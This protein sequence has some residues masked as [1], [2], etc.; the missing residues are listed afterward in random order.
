MKINYIYILII[1]I[2]SNI[3]TLAQDEI[4]PLW[5]GKIPGEIYNSEYFEKEIVNNGELQRTIQV[6]NPTLLIFKP[7]RANG[8][9]ILIFPGGGYEH[10]SMNKEGKKV[11]KWLNSLGITAVILKYRLPN[12]LIMKDKSIG[13][14]Q[15]AQEAMKM[16]RQNASEW[17]INPNKIGVM[18]FSAG[19]HIA[20]TLAT[21]Y[22]LKTYSTNDTI[23]AR[24]DFSILIYPVIS[25]KNEITHKGS[26]ENLLGKNCSN[27]MIE[28]FSNELFINSNTPSTFLVHASDDKAVPVENSI[29]YYLELKKNKVS[30][31]MHIYEKGGH[32]FGLDIEDTNKNWTDDLINWLKNNNYIGN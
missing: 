5:K 3:K 4:I 8:T 26:Q 18:G 11:A 6:V 20:T 22:D 31:E 14:L 24:P 29:N 9:T 23:S 28:K 25:M 1:L 30:A 13:P 19:G 10:L 27:E 15:D 32:G 7:I 2:T 16:I 17:K 12:D 21:R